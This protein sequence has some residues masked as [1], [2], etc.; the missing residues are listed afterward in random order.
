MNL[1]EQLT[2]EKDKIKIR[3]EKLLLLDEERKQK[4]N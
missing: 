1:S 2:Q 4:L 3:D